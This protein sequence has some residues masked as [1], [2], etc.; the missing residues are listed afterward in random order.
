MCRG[1]RSVIHAKYAK[2]QMGKNE[3]DIA[4]LQENMKNITDIMHEGFDRMEKVISGHVDNLMKAIEKKAD[5]DSIDSK[6]KPIERNQ[7]IIMG[8]IISVVVAGVIG[9]MLRYGLGL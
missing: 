8:I 6:I 4:R 1:I 7:N 3:T 5:K 9:F 2:A